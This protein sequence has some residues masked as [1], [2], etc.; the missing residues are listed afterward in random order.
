[1]HQTSSEEQVRQNQIVVMT[2]PGVLGRTA[3]LWGGRIVDAFANIVA[4]PEETSRDCISHQE[5]LIL[6]RA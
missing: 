6:D 1:M 2:T 4:Q 3:S 5:A